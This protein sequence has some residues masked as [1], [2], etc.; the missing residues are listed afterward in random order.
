MTL[1]DLT[2]RINEI[3]AANVEAAKV[4]EIQF[5]MS[6]EALAKA[7]DAADVDKVAA[8][9]IVMGRVNSMAKELMGNR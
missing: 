8:A 6:I 9:S 4:A 3:C 5:N 1:D 2:R 7:I